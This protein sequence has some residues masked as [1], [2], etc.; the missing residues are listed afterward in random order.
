MF[1]YSVEHVRGMTLILDESV[2][3]IKHALTSS[4][5]FGKRLEILE[6][7][8][9][10]CKLADRIVLS[11]GNQSDIVVDYISKISGKPQS[12]FKMFITAR[13]PPYFL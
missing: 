5:L 1:E 10:I 2:S 9:I 12:R 8:E 11:D 6:R 7:L 13:L 4:T 3:V